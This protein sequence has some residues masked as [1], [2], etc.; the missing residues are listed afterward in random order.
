VATIVSDDSNVPRYAKLKD[1]MAATKK[2]VP[3][4]KGIDLGVDPT[5]VGAGAARAQLRELVIPKQENKC[6]FI[7]GDS[8][9]EQG[10][11]LAIRLR[12]LKV[13]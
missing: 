3:I 12:Q 1:I 9:E 5:R 4:W 7:P 13:L 2:P 8:P 10:E 6:E 11:R